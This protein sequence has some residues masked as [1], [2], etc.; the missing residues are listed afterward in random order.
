MIPNI[1]ILQGNCLNVLNGMPDESVHCCVTSPPYW[2]LRDYGHKDQIGQEKT[3]WEYVEKLV[4]VFREVRRVLRKDGTCWVNLGDT[5]AGSGRGAG[6]VHSGNRGNPNSRTGS[7]VPC[8]YHEQARQGGAIGRA[9]VPAPAGL[10]QKDLVGIPWR[11]AFALQAD[12]WYLRQEIIWSKPNPMP[13]SVEDRCTKAHE[14]IFLLTKSPRY[15]FDHEA[16][17]EE[18]VSSHPPGNINHKAVTAYNGGADEHRTKS[19]LLNY[20]ARANDSWKGSQFHTGKPG[21]HQL[22]LA[23]KKRGEFNGKTNG[24]PGREAFRAITEERNKRSVWTVPSAPY[25]GAHFATFPPNL[26]KPCIMAGCPGGG[27]SPRSILWERDIRRG[28]TGTRTQL[29][30]YRVES[31]VHRSG[32]A[33]HFRHAR[34]G[35]GGVGVNAH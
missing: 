16:I 26:I 12:G 13:E 9:W 24:L 7:R 2:G 32:Q 21:Q 35:L 34:H 29:H 5:Y 20:A 14:Q 25:K 3:P 19:G 23:S 27:Y 33:A 18:A 31:G 4:V 1:T 11:V 15:Y 6:D 22:G 28:G 17:K 30:R 10:K 8:G